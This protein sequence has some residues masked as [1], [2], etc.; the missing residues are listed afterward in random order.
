[1]MERH[2]ATLAVN[3]HWG[4][5]YLTL[6]EVLFFQTHLLNLFGEEA[7]LYLTAFLKVV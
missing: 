6:S 3:F 2:I 4:I 7:V 5:S 1:M